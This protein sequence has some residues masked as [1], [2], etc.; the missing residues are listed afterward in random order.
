MD[1]HG[2]TWT[3]TF[4]HA[5]LGMNKKPL[6]LR[7]DTIQQ[8]VSHFSCLDCLKGLMRAGKSAM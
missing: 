3:S 5:R 4:I 2:Q 1:M 7:H 8:R 6:C